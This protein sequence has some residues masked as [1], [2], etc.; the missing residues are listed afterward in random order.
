MRN[1]GCMPNNWGIIILNKSLSRLRLCRLVGVLILMKGNSLT[2]MG[3]SAAFLSAFLLQ[4]P[5]S[6]HA[7]L[8]SGFVQYSVKLVLLC[9][10]SHRSTA[11]CCNQ[12][13][14]D[15]LEKYVMRRMGVMFSWFLQKQGRK[16]LPLKLSSFKRSCMCSRSIHRSF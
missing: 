8:P 12:S 1:L 14:T 16:S 13:Q 6:L 3:L 5:L 15:N 2:P 7:S 9:P 4:T 11:K 10:L